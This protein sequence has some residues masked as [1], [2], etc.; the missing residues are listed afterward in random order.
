MVWR[1]NAARFA[2]LSVKQIA[3]KRI[4]VGSKSE[5]LADLAVR[6]KRVFQVDAEIGEIR[7]WALRHGK[8]LPPDEHGNE[9]W[10]KR[11][12]FQVSG[13]FAEFE[14]ADDCVGHDAETDGFDC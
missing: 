14:C 3:N 12:H 8:R 4:A 2:R 7:S 10:R 1:K 9:I 13:T 11:T 6:Q 5:C